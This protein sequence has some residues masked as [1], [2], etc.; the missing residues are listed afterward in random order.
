MQFQLKKLEWTEKEEERLERREEREYVEQKRKEEREHEERM[1]MYEQRVREQER[2]HALALACVK[3]T[4]PPDNQNN[5]DLIKYIKLV[6]R[7]NEDDVGK[8]FVS[9]EKV[10]N[11]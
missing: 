5:F 3:N 6:P 11:H 2:E 1:K 4:T 9:F 10:E 8:L 7:F